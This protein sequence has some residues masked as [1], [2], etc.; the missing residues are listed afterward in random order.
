MGMEEVIDSVRSIV[1]KWVNTSRPLTADADIGDDIISVTSS[2][3]LKVNDQVMLRNALVYETGF[4]IEEIIDR[5]TIRLSRPVSS[6]DWTVDENTTLIK[7]INDM[8]V[9][10]V[11]FGDPEVIPFYPAISVFG[12]SRASEWLTL[13]S[14][15]E[16]YELQINVY[17]EDGSHEAG[18]RFLHKITDAIQ[19]GLKKNIYPLV[20]DFE[21]TAL[22]ADVASG[23]FII[24][25]SD[26]SIFTEG[27]RIFIEDDFNLQESFVREVLDS[28]TVQL[29][30][31]I[32]EEY[33]ASDSL[34]IVPTRFIYN[35]WP[36][37]IDYGKIHKGSLL[38]ASTISW[39]ANEEEMQLARTANPQLL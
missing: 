20:G 23:D 8:F 10:A 37:T 27:N 36:A 21:T 15:S 9:H 17:V 16:R 25:V 31:N 38:Q 6:K 34:V 12:E 19:F 3:R 33:N 14:T 35:S 24:K 22:L 7:T 4:L 2:K 28:Q 11:Y 26:S 5:Y 39:F 1:S 13:D 18:H 29:W 32:C 30:Q